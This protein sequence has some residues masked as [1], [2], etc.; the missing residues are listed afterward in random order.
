MS[1]RA[2]DVWSSV[3]SP[4]G[5]R[6]GSAG[7]KRLRSG[8]KAPEEPYKFGWVGINFQIVLSEKRHIESFN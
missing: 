2:P 4:M 7:R 6:I 3:L 1:A 5:E 8:E